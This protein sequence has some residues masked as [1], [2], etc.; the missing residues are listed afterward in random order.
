MACTDYDVICRQNANRERKVPQEVI[1]RMYKNMQLPRKSEGWDEIRFITHPDNCQDLVSRLRECVG[2]DQDNSHHDYDLYNH[3]LA[4]AEYVANHCSGLCQKEADLAFKAALFHDIGKIDTKTYQLWSGK[5]DNQAHYYNHA[6][7]GAYKIACA[8]RS[9]PDK[10][11]LA[12][13][14]VL[15]QWHM[16]CYANPNWLDE[17]EKWYGE[18]ARKIMEIVHEGDKEGH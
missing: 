11:M 3:Q 5:I 14:I 15:V 12:D 7:V 18:R 1:D 6:E 4:A 2:V 13:L 9:I 10:E 17:F 8:E 16:D